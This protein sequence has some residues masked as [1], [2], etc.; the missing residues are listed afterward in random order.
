MRLNCLEI[1]VLNK[2][3]NELENTCR[4]IVTAYIVGDSVEEIAERYSLS[5]E[6]T[7]ELIHESLMTITADA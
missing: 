3:L 1:E 6:V 4:A 5:V 2:R 7:Q